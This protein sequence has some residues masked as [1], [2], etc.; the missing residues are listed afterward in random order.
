MPSTMN[1]FTSALLMATATALPQI[2]GGKVDN[3]MPFLSSGQSDIAKGEVV[4][5]TGTTVWWTPE[6]TAPSAT[7]VQ[8]VDWNKAA[9][10]PAVTQPSV[11]Y[12]NPFTIYTSMTDSRGVITGMPAVITAQP[13]QAAVATICSGCAEVS[14]QQASYSSMVA[15]LYSTSSTA[16]RSNTTMATATSQVASSSASASATFRQS[17]AGSRNEVVGGAVL[18]FAGALVALL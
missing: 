6:S 1:F 10:S 15:S 14:S 3:S 8:S 16:V 17:G 11:P 13:S 9:S 7:S 4:A 5:P 12:S 18:A 2:F